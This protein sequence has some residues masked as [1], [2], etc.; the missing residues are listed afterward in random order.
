MQSTYC[1]IS[2]E[3][4][5]QTIKF[6]QLIEYNRRNI[7][8]EKWYKKC[9]GEASPRLFHKKWKLRISL[10]QHS[11]MLYR[12]LLLCVQVEVYQ[13]ILKLRYLLPALTLHTY[14]FSKK[15]KEA[16]NE[17]FCLTF[18][19]IFEEKYFSYRTLLTDQI[20]LS[21]CFYFLR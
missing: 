20:S 16:W 11:K 8:H 17:S 3:V 10:D 13:N 9:G 19:I 2:Q 4:S 5:N 21:Y 14:S 7:T 12:L 6:G 18:G 1:L 15:Q